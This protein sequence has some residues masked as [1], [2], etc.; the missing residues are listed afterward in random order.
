V[1]LEPIEAKA[2]DGLT[3][4]P[5]NGQRRRVPLAA[6]RRAPASS[7]TA[8]GGDLSRLLPAL[9]NALRDAGPG[10][11][12]LFDEIDAVSADRPAPRGQTAAPQPA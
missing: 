9:R 10:R 12:L 8:S 3:H 11:V 6:N 7:A 4:R 5:A 2:A 1:A